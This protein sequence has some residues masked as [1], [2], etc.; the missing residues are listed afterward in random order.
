MG[1]SRNKPCRF[2]PAATADLENIWAFGAERWSP[3]QAVR[4]LADL[5]NAIERL[6]DNPNIVRERIEFSPPV[7][8]YTFRSHIV[9]F[10]DEEDHLE[11]VRV[12]H[13]R[14]DWAADLAPPV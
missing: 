14:E 6:A 12:R 1:Q 7:R 3:G 11:I 13:G 9:I 5:V 10:R 2:R 8:I 4:Y